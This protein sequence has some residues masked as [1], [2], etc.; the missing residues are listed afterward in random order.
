MRGNIVFFAIFCLNKF[1]RNQVFWIAN[2]SGEKIGIDEL[3]GL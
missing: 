2:S 3:I 1:S